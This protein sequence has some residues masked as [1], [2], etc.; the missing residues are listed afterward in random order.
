MINNFNPSQSLYHQR[1]NCLKGMINNFNRTVP[2]SF[3][4][5]FSR[6]PELDF[7]D[8][9]LNSLDKRYIKHHSVKDTF[10]K[11]VNFREK[12]SHTL[13]DSFY[14]EKS[15]NGCFK[16]KGISKEIPG[17]PSFK[18]YCFSIFSYDI[19]Y[20]NR[21]D[22]L[23]D[24]QFFYD[25]VILTISSERFIDLDKECDI[26]KSVIYDMRKMTPKERWAIRCRILDMLKDHPEWP[27]SYIA[28]IFHVQWETVD[29]IR[30]KLQANRNI[31]YK[32]LLEKSR[33]P[34]ANPRAIA[35]TFIKNS[36]ISLYISYTN[37]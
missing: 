23:D 1:F 10:E 29:S 34:E 30:K 21:C 7:S 27:I 4:D 25:L 26:D 36:K 28:S 31:K 6:K 35:F 9:F 12:F 8:K 5:L 14:F 37:K 13:Y 19:S 32:D 24:C 20:L 16:F 3:Y 17:I 22:M 18:D 33:G 11:F 2:C 15:D